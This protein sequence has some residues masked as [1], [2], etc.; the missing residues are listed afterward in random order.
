MFR[1][2]ETIIYPAWV[3]RDYV[4]IEKRSRPL[5]IWLINNWFLYA[6]EGLYWINKDWHRKLMTPFCYAYDQ[7]IAP[8]ANKYERI[9]SIE[10]VRHG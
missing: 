7:Y 6:H 3:G 5:V 4:V 8:W 10:E 1:K 2:H 9:D